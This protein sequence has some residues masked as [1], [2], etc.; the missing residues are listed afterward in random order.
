MSPAHRTRKS[1]TRTPPVAATA[2]PPADLTPARTRVR[3]AILIGVL[4]LMFLPFAGRAF[5][6][7][8]PLFLWAAKHIQSNPGNPYDFDVNWYGIEQSMSAVMENPP[9]ASYYL[10]LVGSVFGL[11]EV[12]THLAFL[13]P[14]LLAAF[15]T[16]LLARRFCR[17]AVLAAAIAT[18]TPVF[19]VS[20]LT[21]MSDMWMLAFWI[22]AIHVWLIGLER[23]SHL[24]F[25]A[26]AL[27]IVLAALSKDFGIALLPLLIVYSVISPRRR[28]WRWLI[29]A[30]APIV[31]LA[32]FELAA[33]QLYGHGML[34]G[35]VKYATGTEVG[36]GRL[37]LNKLT[38]SFAFLGGCAAS[39][40]FL[41]HRLWSRSQLIA[42]A[43]LAVAT[44]AVVVSG[45][46]FGSRELPPEFSLRLLFAAQLGL[47]LVA[48]IAIVALAISDLR[49]ERNADSWLLALWLFGTFLFAGFVN[50]TVN[51]RSLL[52]IVVPAAI[53]AVR[54]M[55]RLG[56][57][58][59][60]AGFL[61][62]APPLIAACALAV[63]VGWADT[64]LANVIREG[65]TQITTEFAHVRR[66]WFE[67][68]W[69]F[70]YYME[71]HGARALS[72]TKV[73]IDSPTS[74]YPWAM[75][76]GDLIVIPGTNT[77]MTPMPHEWYT[78]K[79]FVY[80]P[81]SGWLGTMNIPIGAGFYSDEFGALPFAFG[82]VDVEQFLLLEVRQQSPSKSGR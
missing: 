39:I 34:L 62:L 11:S 59:T 45:D 68:H 66:I 21:V 26:A 16:F 47:W 65:V 9:L 3:I 5:H 51:G 20:G 49:R 57:A 36:F 76:P 40:A 22:L 58:T 77:N 60:G 42:A 14:T 50:W 35:A 13:V 79:K 32:V 46:H 41:A 56:S 18:L 73:T 2:A 53:L 74:P 38:A 25:G 67:G 64:R 31:A 81:S 27:L 23:N 48:G 54:R 28:T 78:M 43:V 8:D 30:G 55:E 37:T 4:A 24:A 10:A 29:W 69:G 80:L 7:D 70:Q 33:H 71:Q 12:A 6:M 61:R 75:A 52:P 1:Q 15:A 63:A 82:K 19:F 72:L 44:A 17:D